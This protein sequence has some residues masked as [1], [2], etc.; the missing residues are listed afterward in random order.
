MKFK[1]IDSAIG[2]P[3]ASLLSDFLL[4]SGCHTSL[5][6]WFSFYFIEIYWSFIQTLHHFTSQNLRHLRILLILLN[7][8]GHIVSNS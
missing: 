5:C 4:L 3:C 2:F 8:S 6:H 7:S 1:H